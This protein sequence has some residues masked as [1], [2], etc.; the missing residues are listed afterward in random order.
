MNQNQR[1]FHFYSQNHGDSRPVMTVAMVVQ[2]DAENRPIGLGFGFARCCGKDTPQKSR[3]RAIS[4]ARAKA[5][6][7]TERTIYFNGLEGRGLPKFTY[8][9]AND[10]NGKDETSI[11]DVLDERTGYLDLGTDFDTYAVHNRI[12]S[13]IKHLMETSKL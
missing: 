2:R 8:F 7:S 1:F 6:L 4:L 13:S 10:F 9:D 12:A 3:G 5:A 11:N